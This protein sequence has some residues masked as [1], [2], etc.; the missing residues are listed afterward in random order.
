MT[1]IVGTSRLFNE[2]GSGRERTTQRTAEVGMPGI[3]FQIPYVIKPGTVW[4]GRIDQTQEGFEKMITE[5]L[6][7][8]DLYYSTKEKPV[9]RR[10]VLKKSKSE[11]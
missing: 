3:V 1:Y 5:G 2:Q 10:I 4:D 7:Y 9:S 6:V 8:V 11:N